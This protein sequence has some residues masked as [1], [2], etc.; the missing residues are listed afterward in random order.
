MADNLAPA[1]FTKSNKNKDILVDQSSHEY[2]LNKRVGENAYWCCR[3]KKQ[4]GC[5]A[6]AVTTTVEDQVFIAKTSGEHN[7][8][9]AVLKKRVID[10]EKRFV[11]NAGNNPTIA[12]RTVLGDIANTLQNDSLAAATTMSRQQTIKMRIYRARKSAL[13]EDRLPQTLD[14]YLEMD[15]RYKTL[16]S[17]ERFLR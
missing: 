9:S 17:G 15:D 10:I 8:S 11:E 14:D 4:N 1:R 3:K 2:I 5:K 7:H 16:E 12:C 6:S 13:Q